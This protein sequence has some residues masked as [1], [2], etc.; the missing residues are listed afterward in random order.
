[1]PQ[2]EIEI[3]DIDI[4]ILEE[5]EHLWLSGEKSNDPFYIEGELMWKKWMQKHLVELGFIGK[6]AY[7]GSKIVG[8]IQYIPKTEHKVVEIKSILVDEEDGDALIVMSLLDETVREF[9]HPKGYFDNE[10]AK[11]LVTLK[12]PF[13]HSLENAD[14]YTEYGFKPI[15][16]EYE[17]L[18]YYPLTG[19]QLDYDP[20]E[21]ISDLPIDEMDR[22]K[23]LILCNPYSPFCVEEMMNTLE[24]LRKID[25]E[26]PVKM[27]I[28]FEEPD[29]FSRF[30]SIPLSLLI[31]GRS[32]GFS[33]GDEERF[34]KN[35]RDALHS[36]KILVENK[37]PKM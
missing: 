11:A 3:K 35:M 24:E 22:D 27:V 8:M 4:E 32:V 31:S 34:L 37:K 13:S 18:L 1:M 28:P 10:R 23:A 15:S 20:A 7:R 5:L 16:N 14:F 33:T 25:D 19:E 30:Y 9:E 36:E 6:A 2:D 26:I 17:M 29:E 12:D 21:S